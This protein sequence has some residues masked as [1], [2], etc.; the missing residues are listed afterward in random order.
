MLGH[1]KV[2]H[3]VL[4]LNN[5]GQSC[6]QLIGVLQFRDIDILIENSDRLF[7]SSFLFLANIQK[8]LYSGDVF[9]FV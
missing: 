5:R 3:T 9:Y 1:S 2:V 7:S 4:L 8:Q 6:H